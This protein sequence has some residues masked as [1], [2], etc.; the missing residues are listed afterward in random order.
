MSGA[1]TAPD[2]LVRAEAIGR[3]GHLSEA[4]LREHA[5]DEDP[6]VRLSVVQALHERGELSEDDEVLLEAAAPD[7][8]LASRSAATRIL[9]GDPGRHPRTIAALLGDPHVYVRAAARLAN[10]AHGG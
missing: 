5:S 9:R 7:E 3:A 4:Q 10:E 1:L 8:A 2:G 6:T